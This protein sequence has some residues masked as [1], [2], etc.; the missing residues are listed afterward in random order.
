MPLDIERTMEKTKVPQLFHVPE[1]SSSMSPSGGSHPCPQSPFP[2]SLPLCCRPRQAAAHG[3]DGSAQT[4][5]RGPGRVRREGPQIQMRA[6]DSKSSQ[7]EAAGV[8]ILLF[9]Q[10]GGIPL[11]VHACAT[12]LSSDIIAC[13]PLVPM[14]VLVS[15]TELRCCHLLAA[16]VS[17]GCWLR[18][19]LLLSLQLAWAAACLLWREGLPC[20]S[21]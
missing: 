4:A 16:T 15:G 12:G 13:L 20:R 10:Y 7:I 5:R 21:H 18:T 19:C 11:C 3:N 17:C 8:S 9:P 14:C 2:T 6:G 1:L